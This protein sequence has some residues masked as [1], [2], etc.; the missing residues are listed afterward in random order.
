VL[1]IADRHAD[2]AREVGTELR[3][4]GLRVAVDDRAESVGRKIRDGELRKVPY[5]LVVGDREA[6]AGEVAVRRHGQ[7]DQGGS[8]VADFADRVAGE[9][10]ART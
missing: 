10:A 7:G 5:L 6:E 4:A 9:V 1:P 8:S 3:D 2:Y